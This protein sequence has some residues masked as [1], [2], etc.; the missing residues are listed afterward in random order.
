MHFWA[1]P[2]QHLADADIFQVLRRERLTAITDSHSIGQN[3]A[4]SHPL[5]AHPAVVLSS[6]RALCVETRKVNVPPRSRIVHGGKTAFGATGDASLRVLRF[7]DNV[8]WCPPVNKIDIS[9]Q[10]NANLPSPQMFSMMHTARASLLLC[11][12]VFAASA[13]GGY[14]LQPAVRARNFRNM[15][16]RRVSDFSR[17]SSQAPALG[18]LRVGVS[19]SKGSGIQASKKIAR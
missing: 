17:P 15:E 13:F 18:S 2:A 14:A 16:L 8:H 9:G 10:P 11:C 6:G 1:Q 7:A 3:Q 4:L 5:P 12:H 19:T